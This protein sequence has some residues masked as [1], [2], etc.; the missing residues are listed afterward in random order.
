MTRKNYF[1]ASSVGIATLIL[2]VLF[3]PIYSNVKAFKWALYSIFT[4]LF[5]LTNL[6]ILWG[7]RQRE[8]YFYL[9]PFVLSF[10]TATLITI[11]LVS[12]GDKS[13]NGY[14]D[15][16]LINLLGVYFIT[17]FFFVTTISLLI[18]A[19]LTRSITRINVFF[20]LFGFLGLGLRLLG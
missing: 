4:S 14:L 10:L 20:I 15:T 9:L 1:I 7:N 13:F 3:L 11:F 8:L 2:C 5:C 18:Y 6:F 17:G 12:G 16:F 19:C